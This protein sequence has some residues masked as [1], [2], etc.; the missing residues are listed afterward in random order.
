M[1]SR[2]SRLGEV[3]GRWSLVAVVTADVSRTELVTVLFSK[4]IDVTAH[5]GPNYLCIS[6]S[7]EADPNRVLSKTEI[8]RLS[9]VDV[10]HAPDLNALRSGLA[11]SFM[12]D[13]FV[14]KSFDACVFRDLR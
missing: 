2:R 1:K 9:L 14:G 3:P 13:L 4:E 6:P 7:L 10:V 5:E 12:F 8:H 11:G